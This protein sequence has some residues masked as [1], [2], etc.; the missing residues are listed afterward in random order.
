MSQKQNPWDLPASVED[1]VWRLGIKI[2]EDA[3]EN[4]EKIYCDIC[5]VTGWCSCDDNKKDDEDK[6]CGCGN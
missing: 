6:N 3:W 5:K 4:R 1:A 2:L